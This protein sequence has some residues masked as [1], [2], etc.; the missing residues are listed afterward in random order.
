[1]SLVA[2]DVGGDIFGAIVLETPASAPYLKS[3][4][5]VSILFKE[6]EVSLAKNLTGAI[7]IRNRCQ[8]RVNK[9]QPHEIL[10]SVVL[11]YK[12]KEIVSI[13]PT[14]SLNQLG[15]K[16]G[17]DIEWLVKTNEVSLWPTT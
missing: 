3:G 15:L 12:G 17:E 16:A 11:D 2:V 10:S 7:S 14:R 1:M 5:E 13:I 4:H 8:A 6:T 9:I